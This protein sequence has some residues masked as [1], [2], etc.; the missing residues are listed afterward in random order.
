MPHMNC[1][2]VLT[3]H[4]II[5]YNFKTLCNI[6]TSR[7]NYRCNSKFPNLPKATV[8]EQ[9]NIPTQSLG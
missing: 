4:D 8:N 3:K 7:F 2:K 6:K 9:M 1:T 5:F